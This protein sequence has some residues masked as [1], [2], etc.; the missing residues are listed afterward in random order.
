MVTAWSMISLVYIA[1]FCTL[2][3]HVRIMFEWATVSRIE[4]THVYVNTNSIVFNLTLAYGASLLKTYSRNYV[5][6][7]KYVAQYLHTLLIESMV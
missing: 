6:I 2:V 4:N 3:F 7:C 1:V 5:N